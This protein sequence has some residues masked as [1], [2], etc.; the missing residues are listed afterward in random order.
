MCGR[1]SLRASPVELAD[2]FGLD[3]VPDLTPRYNIAPTQPIAIVMRA[4]G[5]EKRELHEVRFG[6]VPWWGKDAS[7]AA[8]HINARVETIFEKRPFV[9][10]IR[11]RRCLVVVDGFYEWKRFEKGT[12]RPSQP[13]LIHFQGDAPFALAGVWDRWV[14]TDGEVVESCAIVTG[15][16]KGGV[17]ELHDRM[18]LVVPQES[19]EAWLARD[20][21][22]ATL[23]ETFKNA[24]PAWQIDAVSRFVNDPKHEGP[25]CI[26]PANDD[27]ALEAEPLPLF[28]GISES[29]TAKA[30]R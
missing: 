22:P 20:A 21:D 2:A 27:G 3:H 11:K 23:L 24:S 28:A 17:A 12:K 30:R 10:P 5:S 26:A 14:S 7:G 16:S 13:Y 29:T 25:E 4:R 18:P 6:L 1:T 19:Y 8:K 9:D 15:P